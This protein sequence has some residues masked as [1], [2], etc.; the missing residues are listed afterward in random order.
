[1]AGAG[2]APITIGKWMDI[3]GLDRPVRAPRPVN[4]DNGNSED[5][6][7]ITTRHAK[8]QAAA[9][10]RQVSERNPDFRAACEQLHCSY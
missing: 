9:G 10:G 7:G 2:H 8:R 1:V 4:S 3:M 5:E 6:W